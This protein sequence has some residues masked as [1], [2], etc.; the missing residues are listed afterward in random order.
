MRVAALYSGGKDSTFAIAEAGRQGHQTICL[1]SVAPVSAESHLLHY[2]NT[3]FVGL[4][5]ESMSLPLLATDAGCDG[6]DGEADAMGR[7]LEE[8]KSRFAIGGVIHGG[9]SSGFQKDTFGNACSDKGLEAIAPL[10]GADQREYMRRLFRMR[11]EFIITSVTSGGLDDY[12][13]GRTINESDIDRLDML[14][15]KHGFNISFEGGEAETFV[16]CCP[17]FSRRIMIRDAR[18]SWDG[19]RGRFEILDAALGEPCLTS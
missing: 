12:W 8:A 1:I 4:Q 18:K 10:W 2:P 6:P 14:S 3:G 19:Y 15:H 13:L 17:L 11:F 9:I 16:T 5:A 7:L